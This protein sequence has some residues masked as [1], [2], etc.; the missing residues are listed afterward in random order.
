MNERYR[1]WFLEGREG[2]GEEKRKNRRRGREPRSR[3]VPL[4]LLQK[5]RDWAFLEG[6]ALETIESIF[7][8]GRR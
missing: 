7:W 3:L 2:K 5:K 1:G 8:G 4:K 6:G